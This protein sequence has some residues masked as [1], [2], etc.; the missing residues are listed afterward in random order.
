MPI[1]R[2]RLTNVGPFDDIEFEFDPQVNVFTGPNN[3]GKSSALWALGGVTVYPFAFPDKLLRK[4]RTSKFKLQLCGDELFDARNLVFT[5]VASEHVRVLKEVGYSKFIPA[6]RHSTDFRS[7]GPTTTHRDDEEVQA[8]RTPRLVDSFMRHVHYHPSLTRE[9]AEHLELRERISLQSKDPSIVIDGSVIQRIIDIDYRSYIRQSPRS[10][11]LITAISEM[12]SEITEGFPL[13]FSGVNEDNNGFFP[14]FKTIDGL[15]PLNTLSQGT[16]SIIQWLAHLLIGYAEYYDFP[17]D[18]RDKPGVLIIDE[19][20]AHLHPSW[21]RRIIPTLTERF[22]KLQ[23]FCSTHSP[24]ML[25]GLK[26]GQVQ[27][28]RRDDDGRVTVSRNERDLAGWTADEI[29]R[30]F[31][32]LPDPSDIVSSERLERYQAL[33][34]KTSLSPEEA[35]EKEQ[36]S[37]V[38]RDDLMRGPAFSQARELAKILNETKAE[39][40]FEDALKQ[41]EI[42]ESKCTG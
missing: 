37:H 17:E 21:Q 35:E 33:L 29:L 2:L 39:T 14:E 40:S 23:I 4:E 5:P 20:D 22:P 13:E 10:S 7:K 25:A 24:L 26:T 1:D 3:S 34:Y 6:L 27:L 30:H 18:L 42:G 38:V 15:M 11:N 36:L 8:R 16:Q 12:T 9:E 19:I 28:L 41:T 31:L 32:D